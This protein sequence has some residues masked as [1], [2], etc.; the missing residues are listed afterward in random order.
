MKALNKTLG[1][2]LEEKKQKVSK[3]QAAAVNAF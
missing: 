3:A 2:E 1:K